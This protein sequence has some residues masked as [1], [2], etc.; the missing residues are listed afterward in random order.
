MSQRNKFHL[1]LRKWQDAV[2]LCQQFQCLWLQR[3]ILTLDT[4]FVHMKIPLMVF[5]L[6]QPVGD[7]FF[8]RADIEVSVSQ[9]VVFSVIVQIIAALQY[10]H[11]TVRL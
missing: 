7:E 3:G 2:V 10:R 5:D 9:L 8:Q 11:N 6:H 1:M 4:E